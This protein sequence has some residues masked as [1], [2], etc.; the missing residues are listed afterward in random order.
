MGEQYDHAK[1]L[2]DSMSELVIAT[3]GLHDSAQMVL[4]WAEEE[5]G[6]DHQWPQAFYN[7]GLSVARFN[8]E[9]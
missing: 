6:E 1:R 3:K 4:N 9:D 8:G 7:L 5:W 2:L